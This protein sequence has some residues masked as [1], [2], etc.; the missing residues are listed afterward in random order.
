MNEIDESFFFRSYVLRYFQRWIYYETPTSEI[1][2][3]G[4]LYVI[5][6]VGQSS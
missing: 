2:D 6:Q 4:S 5:W 3:S 1:L